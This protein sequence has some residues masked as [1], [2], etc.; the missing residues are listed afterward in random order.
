MPGLYLHPEKPISQ[1]ELEE[2][3]QYQKTLEDQIADLDAQ[4]PADEDSEEYEVWADRHE[5]LE[6]LLDEV[7]DA[8]ETFR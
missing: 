2:L 4:E 5:D 1:L 3:I 7:L 6:D 8:A